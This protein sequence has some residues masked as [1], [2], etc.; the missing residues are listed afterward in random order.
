MT[1]RRQESTIKPSEATSAVKKCHLCASQ[2]LHVFS[3]TSS[4]PDDT[5][6]W[7]E[8]QCSQNIPPEAVVCRAC[9]KYIKRHTGKTNVTPRW[10]PKTKVHSY[11]MVEGCGELSH[12][13]TSIVSVEVARE[14]LDI[15]QSDGGIS[16][17]LSLCNCHYQYLYRELH[18]PQ[19]CA[20]C[21]S[22]P[23]YGGDYTRHCPDPAKITV[24]LKE[25]FDFSG[26]LT[27][28]SKIC[29]PCYI[30]HRQVLQQLDSSSSA[31]TDTLHSIVFH[32]ETRLA[33]FEKKGVD[34]V[35]DK[36][37]LAWNV[38]KVSLGLTKILQNEEAILLP[39]LYTTFCNY[40]IQTIDKF[41]NVGKTLKTNPPTIRWFLSSISNHL[42]ENLGIVCKHRKYGTL[43]YRRNGDILKAL[44]KALGKAQQSQRTETAIRNDYCSLLQSKSK[45]E[46]TDRLTDAS[47]LQACTAINSKINKQ[48]KSLV[49]TYQRDPLLCAN[50]SPEGFI[51]QLDPLLVQC[52]QV[53][54]QNLQGR[55]G[56]CLVNRT[57]LTALEC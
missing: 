13:T 53:L 5:R 31:V 20:A 26:A 14:Y 52:I 56:S 15:I 40:I 32:L 19:P 30:F 3:K 44:S 10:L 42:G 29:K 1:E 54:T 9:E 35:C 45:T 48:I 25:T 4:W 36:S 17:S 49:K 6:Q 57:Y 27:V 33:D 51:Q 34:T 41:P 16:Q 12:T 11:C 38:C 39:E 47:I 22:Q 37:F 43:L 50:F 24:F 7:V 28:A 21:Y 2:P 55:E 46:S 8:K 23:R 18:Y